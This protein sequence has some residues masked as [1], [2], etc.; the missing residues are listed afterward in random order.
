M[1]QAGAN[2]CAFVLLGLKYSVMSPDPPSPKYKSVHGRYIMIHLFSCYLYGLICRMESNHEPC[3]K[4]HPKCFFVLT[5]ISR[6]P[7]DLNQ[8]HIPIQSLDFRV[9]QA[10]RFSELIHFLLHG[11]H[12]NRADILN[13]RF[14]IPVL[15]KTGLC[16]YIG[17]KC[18]PF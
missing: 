10:I 18:T 11:F 13:F 15:F 9:K 3:P 12:V 7:T 1:T 17:K 2:L 5:F 8:I 14:R 16:G 6:L 4:S